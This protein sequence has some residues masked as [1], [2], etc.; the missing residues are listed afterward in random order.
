MITELLREVL[1]TRRQWGSTD[2]QRGAVVIYRYTK[3]QSCLTT[4]LLKVER[5]KG[6]KKGGRTEHG[7]NLRDGVIFELSLLL[8]AQGSSFADRSVAHDSGWVAKTLPT[9][10]APR[11]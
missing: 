4:L 2:S 1:G 11:A 7:I 6:W 3:Y 8:T 5:A 10:Q 9:P